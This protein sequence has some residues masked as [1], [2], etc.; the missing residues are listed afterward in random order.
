[1][2]TGI[3]EAVG[4]V[5]VARLSSAGGMVAVD[6]G[7]L[8]ELVKIG[9]SVA[10]NGVCLTV[11]K[12]SGLVADFDVSGETVQKAAV[13]RLRAGA[14]VNLEPAMAAD[15]RFGGHIVQGHVDGRA[16]VKAV[17][18][19]GQFCRITF[20]ADAELLD[21][22]VPKGSVAVDGV[23]LTIADMDKGSFSVSV[24]PTT[25]KETTLGTMKVG[26]SVNIET[27]IITRTIKQ[28]L[29]KIYDF[30]LRRWV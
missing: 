27:D 22:M 9:D 18:K 16:Q 17:E 10:V 8:A 11:S 23:S 5:R 30:E 1:M 12:V 14:K 2:F 4:Q 29:K 6:L 3:I 26:D 25:L 20:T 28:Q 19:Q 13:D 15:G 7:N 24:I 21:N